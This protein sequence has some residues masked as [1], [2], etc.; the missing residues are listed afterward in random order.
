MDITT[1]STQMY[2][3]NVHTDINV[4]FSQSMTTT[5]SYLQLDTLETTIAPEESVAQFP[6]VSVSIIDNY[7]LA[8]NYLEM[9]ISNVIIYYI[10]II[11]AIH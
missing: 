3:A 1:L 4:T 8:K 6:D 5:L 9:I 7:Y 10:L 11:G 2:D